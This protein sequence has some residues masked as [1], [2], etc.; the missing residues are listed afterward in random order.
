M[1]EEAG[2][3]DPRAARRWTQRAATRGHAAAHSAH[4]AR[5]TYTALGGGGRRRSW[6]LEA[7]RRRAVPVRAAA[8]AAR[9][10]ACVWATSATVSGGALH[11]SGDRLQGAVDWASAIAARGTRLDCAASKNYPA[12]A[13]FVAAAAGV[14]GSWRRFGCGQRQRAPRE[15]RQ[16]RHGR[17]RVCGRRRRRSAP[18]P[19]TVPAIIWRGKSKGRPLSQ[20]ARR[21]KK[22]LRE[23]RMRT[24]DSNFDRQTLRA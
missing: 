23:K 6:V 9:P 8:A 2:P 13:S 11:W 16:A 22:F 3:R 24:Q 1:Q 15:Q 21:F 20:A 4:R 12:M 10:S 18:A 7:I 5:V 17:P 14:H 19:S